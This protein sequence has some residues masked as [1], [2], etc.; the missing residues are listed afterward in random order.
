MF[1]PFWLRR[2]AGRSPRSNLFST[3][4]RPLRRFL[5]MLMLRSLDL[6]E[7]FFRVFPHRAR[8]RGES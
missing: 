2:L 8:R 6:T 7:D 5:L 3:Q 1:A 4:N